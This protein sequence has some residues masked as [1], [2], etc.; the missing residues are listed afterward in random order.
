[1]YN[2]GFIMDDISKN[3]SKIA[4]T[5]DDTLMCELDSNFMDNKATL[6]VKDRLNNVVCTINYNESS[7]INIMTFKNLTIV[8]TEQ[9]SKY[10]NNFLRSHSTI[11]ENI[12][13]LFTCSNSYGSQVTNFLSLTQ[14]I[15]MINTKGVNV[16]MTLD[17]F[18]NKVLVITESLKGKNI[19]NIDSSQC[20]EYLDQH[21][22]STFFVPSN[23]N[24]KIR[25]VKIRGTSNYVTSE[26]SPK[27]FEFDNF[28]NKIIE[29]DSDNDNDQPSRQWL[30]DASNAIN[31]FDRQL[32]LQTYDANDIIGNC[33]N[34]NLTT[35]NNRQIA[36][37]K[38]TSDYVDDYVYDPADFGDSSSTRNSYNNNKTNQNNSNSNSNSIENQIKKLSGFDREV[39]KNLHIMNLTELKD[40]YDNNF[41]E[42]VKCILNHFDMFTDV[43]ID[44]IRSILKSSGL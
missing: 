26:T 2:S 5:L 32:K 24:N 30:T 25:R 37:P 13:N 16:L 21:I 7:N 1:M 40:L 19:T 39:I 27:Q 10:L 6:V 41:S 28:R 22:V 34:N 33:F 14:A 42:K 36:K 17:Y 20:K 31:A 9:E 23:A 44:N 8:F 18:T 12:T 4:E 43:G 11:Y 15:F 3:F 35:N 29:S 38:Y